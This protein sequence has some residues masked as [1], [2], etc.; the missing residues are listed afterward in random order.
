MKKVFR[1]WKMLEE[2]VEMS[3]LMTTDKEVLKSNI[4]MTIESLKS[5]W[6]LKCEGKTKEECIKLGH[7]FVA[8]TEQWFVEEETYDNDGLYYEAYA[9]RAYNGD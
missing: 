5:G 6:P 2:D 4:K 3:E 1:I 9:N 8:N 7:P